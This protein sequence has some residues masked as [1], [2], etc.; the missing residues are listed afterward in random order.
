MKPKRRDIF[1]PEKRSQVMSKIRGHYSKLDIRMNEILNESGLPYQMYPD[2]FGKPDFLVGDRIAVF[3]DSS[4]WHGRNWSKLR[5]KLLL[6]RNSDYWVS[7]INA[8]KK[9]DRRVTAEL[10][11]RGFRVARF[12]DVEIQKVPNSVLGKLNS[13]SELIEGHG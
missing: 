2:L 1:S 9:R 3:C 4:F 11:R 13:E 12:W 6:G 8:N 5:R 7:H 10:R